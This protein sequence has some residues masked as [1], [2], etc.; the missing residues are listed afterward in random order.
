AENYGNSDCKLPAADRFHFKPTRQ[1]VVLD[2]WAS[3][4]V[5]TV[6]AFTTI[7]NWKQLYRVVQYNGEEYYWSKHFEFLKFLDLP[8]R[9]NQT[10]ELALS[11][12]DGEDRTLLLSH[13]W[14]V[15]DALSFSHDL[16]AYRRYILESKA[17]F[18]VAK[19]QNIRLRTGWF[20]DR[21]AT[22][23]ASGRP[24]L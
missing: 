8:R 7:G 13:G 22:Y 9:A 2:F 11:G 19:D 6:D 3:D 5:P 14:N 17:E 18:T 4:A 20:S 10:I 16:N 12:C 21:S 15:R 24:V 23:L 1:P